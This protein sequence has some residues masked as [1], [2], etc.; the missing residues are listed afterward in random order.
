MFLGKKEE[1]SRA[2]RE[3]SLSFFLYFSFFIRL[4][5]ANAKKEKGTRG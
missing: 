1:I 4:N 3:K 2:S 5:K